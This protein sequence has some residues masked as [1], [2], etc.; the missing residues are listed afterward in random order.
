MTKVL[1]VEDE[2]PSARKLK[3]FILEIEPNFEIVDILDSVSTTVSFLENN[4]VDLI[5]LDIHLSDGNSFDIFKKTDVEV[6]IIFT[7]AFNQ[8]AIDA[9]KQISVDYLLKP[10]DKELLRSAINKFNKI[11]HSANKAAPF[12]YEQLKELLTQ[13][14]QNKEYQERFLVHYRDKI[15]SIN[16]SEIA[17]FY[18]DNKYVFIK[19]FDNQNFD[20]NFTLEQLE[21]KLDPKHFFRA[22]RKCLIHINS[23]K[24]AVVYSKSKLK[25]NINPELPFE[26]IISTEKSPKFKQWLSQ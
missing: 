4:T 5:F 22:N 16:T 20:T 24:D 8:Y 6:P 15:K 13:S 25:L 26:I 18:A 7:T 14:K 23:I 21:H 17:A 2:M 10:L 19:T 9:F 11:Y 3:N 1:I 12:N